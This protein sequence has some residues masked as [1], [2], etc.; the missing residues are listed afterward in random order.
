MIDD[1][2][3]LRQEDLE[4]E[5]VLVRDDFHLEGNERLSFHSV[6]LERNPKFT[7]VNT[8]LIFKNMQNTMILGT[9]LTNQHK[10]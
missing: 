4:P 8:F 6:S 1:E 7:K 10:T 3:G 9:N 5:L 2:L